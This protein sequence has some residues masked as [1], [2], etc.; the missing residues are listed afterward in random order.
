MHQLRPAGIKA[1]AVAIPTQTREITL[2]SGKS[3]LRHNLPEGTSGL[4]MDREAVEEVLAAA[5]VDPKEIDLVV[6]ATFPALPEPCIGNATPLAW[7]L[8][9]TEAAAY[10]MESACAG[11][12]VALRNACHEVA[13]GEHDNVL[14]TVGCPYSPTVEDGH[15]AYD[16]IGDASYAMLIG[17]TR[18]GQEFLGSVIRNSGPTCPLVSWAVSDKT[19]SG[20]R[21]EVGAKTAGK[22][23]EWALKQ[24]PELSQRLFDRAGLAR[25]DVKHWAINAPTPSFADRALATMGA[26]PDGGVNTNRLVGNVGPSLIGVSLFYNAQL[27]DMR[28]GDLVACCSVGSEASL[29]LTLMRWPENVALGRV[30]S[31]ASVEAMKGYEAERLGEL[32][33]V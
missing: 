16:V 26:D 28:P 17:P 20:I 12:L 29:A 3:A 15:P 9:M 11:G 2:P 1:L 21:L 30:P 32:A 22:L 19:S 18:Q 8:G 33:A 5:A 13:L 7:E 27:R 4:D 6:S 23:E 14:V 25:S 24:I 10:N 31:H